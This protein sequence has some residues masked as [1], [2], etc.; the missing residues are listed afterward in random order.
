MEGIFFY[1]ELLDFCTM[2]E[3]ILLFEMLHITENLLFSTIFYINH[4]MGSWLY[5]A[6]VAHSFQVI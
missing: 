6:L 4:F 2:S 1:I 3:L 5:M